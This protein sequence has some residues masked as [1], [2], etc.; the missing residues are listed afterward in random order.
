MK[1]LKNCFVAF[2]LALTLSISALAGEMPG[3]GVA[4]VQPPPVEADGEMPGAGITA[5]ATEIMLIIV[6]NILSI[7]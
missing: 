4:A 1:N 6:E 2:I 7:L 3:A 5:P